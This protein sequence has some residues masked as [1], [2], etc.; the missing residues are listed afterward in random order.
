V[1]EAAF[2][3]LVQHGFEGLRVR[4]V[5]IKVG[6]NQATLLYHFSDKEELIVALVDEL[7]GRMRSL[8]EG[9]YAIAPGSLGAFESHLRTLLELFI[10]NPA[11]YV[12]FNEIG[13]RAIRDR[14]IAVKLAAVEQDWVTYISSLLRAAAATAPQNLIDALARSTVIYVR[15]IVAKAAGDGTLATLVARRA[16]RM[17]AHADLG[18]AVE[19]LIDMVRARLAA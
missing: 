17:Q 15:G 3:Q 1:L 4:D 11:I 16:G 12:A 2:R 14:R 5:A 6:I 18:A 9:Q 7:V 13:A 19:T 10:A 8:N